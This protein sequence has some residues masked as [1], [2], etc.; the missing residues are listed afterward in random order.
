MTHKNTFETKF[1]NVL[2]LKSPQFAKIGKYIRKQDEFGRWRVIVANILALPGNSNPQPSD[3]IERD[4][5][6]NHRLVGLLLPG[7]YMTRNLYRK[8]R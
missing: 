1:N 4:P 6:G 2:I 5:S 8:N 7:N 3:P